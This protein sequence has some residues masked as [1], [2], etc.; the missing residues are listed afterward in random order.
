MSNF[1][2]LRTDRLV[3]RRF[4][5]GDLAAFLA[6]RNDP[7][8]MRYDGSHGITQERARA[9]LLEQAAIPAGEPGIWLQIAVELPGVGLIGDC[10]FQVE[11]QAPDAAEVG[12]RLAREW[13]GHGYASEAVAGVLNWAFDALELHR[14]TALIDTRNARSIGVV[15]RLGFRREGTFLESYREPYGWSDEYLYAILG[16]EWAGRKAA[17]D[18]HHRGGARKQNQE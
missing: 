1:P 6:Y 4:Q 8:V 5:S 16:R 13:W 9:F 3:L 2:V 10:G 7:E 15:E 12:Y 11:E 17:R 14:V 18:F